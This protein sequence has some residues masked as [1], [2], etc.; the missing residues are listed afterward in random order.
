MQASSEAY[1]CLLKSRV[2][3]SPSVFNLTMQWSMRILTDVGD[4]DPKTN[5]VNLCCCP[6]KLKMFLRNGTMQENL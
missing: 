4:T 6:D 5:K 1:G 2:A 3:T